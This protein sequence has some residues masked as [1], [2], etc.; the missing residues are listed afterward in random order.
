MFLE[1]V[2]LTENVL[3]RSQ[4]RPVFTRDSPADSNQQQASAVLEEEADEAAVPSAHHR[5]TYS[6]TSTHIS[7]GAAA[8]APQKRSG[9]LFRDPSFNRLRRNSE[10]SQG[11]SPV[12]DLCLRR[13]RV[14]TEL[15]GGTPFDSDES[16]PPSLSET[17]HQDRE[18]KESIFRDLSA[19]KGPE[20]P[21]TRPYFRRAETDL[22]PATSSQRKKPPT[23]RGLP[24]PEPFPEFDERPASDPKHSV[25]LREDYTPSQLRIERPKFFR[26]PP[27]ESQARLKDSLE[28]VYHRRFT[29]ESRRPDFLNS[30]TEGD[31]AP[32]SSSPF[33]N[34]LPQDIV[35]PCPPG[36]P[37]GFPCSAPR[38]YPS[39]NLRSGP[40]QARE[41]P[42]VSKLP[43][44][45]EKK[46]ESSL[47]QRFPPKSGKK[48][49]KR[50]PAPAA[51]LTQFPQPYTFETSDKRRFDPLNFVP[52]A[53]EDTGYNVTPD[54][55]QLVPQPN[56]RRT[57][58]GKAPTFDDIFR[59]APH[60]ASFDSQLR[61]K[62]ESLKSPEVEHGSSDSKAKK[63]KG[64]FRLVGGLKKLFSPTPKLTS[65]ELKAQ[66]T[67]PVGPEPE[68]TP[69]FYKPVLSPDQSD[70]NDPQTEEHDP[71]T[72]EPKK[73]APKVAPSKPPS[74]IQYRKPRTPLPDFVFPTRDMEPSRFLDPS[75]AMMV[76]TKQKRE[77]SK[78]AK[79]QATAVKE[80]CRRAN[81]ETPP[82]DFEELIGKGAYGR[83]YK[84]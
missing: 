32:P 59:S 28:E 63:K 47:P 31:S 53:A 3:D 57:S 54:S 14:Y 78:L 15:I 48:E 42:P 43:D 13:A 29:A 73:V 38:P 33:E 84:G 4:Y 51:V 79:E 76:V 12:R 68:I 26:A 52:V 74:G 23:P 60:H 39:E 40:S 20:L 21:Q 25:K 83:V 7:V 69:V 9:P 46:Q 30:P 75:S 35:S 11:S 62:G 67:S 71:Q 24:P 2:E 58:P 41:R 66:I 44:Q 49:P 55:T 65:E 61:P 17:T 18:P 70:E 36:R 8:E 16:K 27:T 10:S 77:A 37:G 34:S 5:R 64:S 22:P 80:M 56:R 45:H 72:E 6:E 50:K 82:Y 19:W 81:T 1:T